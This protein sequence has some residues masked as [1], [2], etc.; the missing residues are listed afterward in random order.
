MRY[1]QPDPESGV[2]E[3]L[4]VA[5][6][7][8]PFQVHLHEQRYA[9]AL[10]EVGP[11]D[12]LLE[13]GT[14]LGIFSARV[15]HRVSTYRGIEYDEQACAVAKTRVENPEWISQ[16]DAQDLELPDSV[17]SAV[18][19]LE[20]LE[21]LPN[22]RKALGEI[23]RVLRPGGRLIVSIPY[24]RVGA[25]SR[26]NPHH[27]Y[28]PG[29][30][31]FIAE[32]QKRFGKL[33]VSYQRYEETLFESIARKLRVR[34]LFGLSAQYARLSAGESREMEKVLLDPTRSGLLLGLFVVA[35]DPLK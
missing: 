30:R 31:E 29:E 6:C 8:D 9:K 15:A 3:R 1:D 18:I 12:E 19:C 17:F 4:D 35:S 5:T 34:R 14:G 13:I 21:H 27:L 2:F 10:S 23:A 22:Y 11:A 16:G 32:L 7:G 26:T 20:V 24:A 33:S 28:E 25:P